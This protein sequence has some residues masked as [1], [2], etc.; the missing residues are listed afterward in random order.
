MKKILLALSLFAF[1]MASNA[2]LIKPRNNNNESYTLDANGKLVKKTDNAD[3]TSTTR[4]GLFT[5]DKTPIAE[6]Y[7]AGSC[8]EVNGKIQWDK[9][10]TTTLT[11]KQEYDIM[12]KFMQAFVKSNGQTQKSNVSLVDPTKH[13][14][15]SHLA[16]YLIFENKP[17]SLDQ[18]LMSYNLIVTCSNG[19][20]DVTM[21][22]ISFTYEEDR[23]GGSFPGE[24]MLSDKEAL[25]KKKDGFNKGGYKKFRTKTIDR[26]DQIFNMI[27]EALK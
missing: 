1:C 4:K 12:E 26:K 2:Q 24:D 21:R 17:L 7:L 19:R 16:E 5:R 27:A 22:N 8:P 18:A 3:V 11:A 6:K 15:A 10:I 23:D 25:N 14:I 13:Q 9:T 20:V